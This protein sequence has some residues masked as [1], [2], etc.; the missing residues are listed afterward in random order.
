MFP[1]RKTVA[2]RLGDSGYDRGGGGGNGYGPRKVLP[3]ELGIDT[4][5]PWVTNLFGVGSGAEGSPTARERG[6]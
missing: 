2:G 1:G 3:R 5:F 6:R 4:I